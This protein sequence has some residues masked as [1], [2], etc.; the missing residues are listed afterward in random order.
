MI[1]SAIFRILSDSDN[2]VLG[3]IREEKSRTYFTS[4]V[5]SNLISGIFLE[6]DIVLQDLIIGIRP[7]LII[8][9]V[10]LTKHRQTQCTEIDM[11]SLNALLPH[12]LANICRFHEARLL[13]ISTDCVFSGDR[14]AYSEFD[15]PNSNDIYGKSKALGEISDQ[16]HV[17][18]VRTSTIGH[19]IGTCYGLLEW[20]LSQTV[21]CRGYSNAIFSG[22][23]SI[24]LAKIIRD[25]IIPNQALFGLYNISAEPID[26]FSLLKLISEVYGRSILIDRDSDFVMNRSLDS[27]K[28]FKATGYIA[29][30]WRDLIVSMYED[31]RSGGRYV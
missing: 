15:M 1:G 27:Q 30:N 20:F 22:L 2:V 13:H 24:I 23:P 31:S 6:N 25:V 5:S 18:T 19:E 8:N 21:S 9:C 17:L 4:D 7:N 28:F 26:K 29:P 14:G 11:I 16:P 10:G 12:R 3:T